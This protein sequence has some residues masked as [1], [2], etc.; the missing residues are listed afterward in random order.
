LP[1]E[2]DRRIL[3]YVTDRRGITLGD[4]PAAET[5]RIA[6]LERLV[7]NAVAAGVDWIQIREKDL[8]GGTLEKVVRAV[9]R[10]SVAKILV[11]DRLDIALATAAGGVHL[12]VRSLSVSAVTTWLRLGNAPAGFLVGASCHSPE[13]AVAA[14]RAGANY[15]FFGPVFKTP[16]KIEFGPPQGLD[17]L[18]AVAACAGIPVIAIGGIT[19][20]NIAECISA[21]A[22]GVAAIR[23]FQ[24]SPDLKQ[25]VAALRRATR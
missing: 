7:A 8:A 25:T 12:G 5:M 24:E 1:R 2:T 6:A 20:E 18:H 22:A 23:L 3:C 9:A 16:A 19:L 10:P 11:N 17:R 15:L 4:G 13:D 21:G 14:E